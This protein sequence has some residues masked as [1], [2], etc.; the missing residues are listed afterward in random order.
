MITRA[1]D[2]SEAAFDTLLDFYATLDEQIAYRLPSECRATID[3]VRAGI[4]LYH[5]HGDSALLS[6]AMRLRIEERRGSLVCPECGS[7]F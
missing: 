2:W 5:T 6:D 7:R 3:V 1:P 4:H